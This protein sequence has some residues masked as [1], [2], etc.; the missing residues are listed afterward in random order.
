MSEG[1]I[2]LRLPV[3]ASFAASP[4]INPLEVE[5]IAGHFPDKKECVV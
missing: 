4:A 2:A 1:R 3:T 5:I